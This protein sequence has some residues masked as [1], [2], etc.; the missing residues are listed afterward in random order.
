MLAV[1]ATVLGVLMFTRGAAA[2]VR[3]VRRGGPAPDRTRAPGRRT[4]RAVSEILGHERFAQR[5]GVR[6]AHW[7]VMLGFP[8]LFL[9][10]V[11]G[12]GQ[13]VDPRYV[14][15]VVGTWM[16]Y[17]WLVD[18]FA[19]GGLVGIVTLIVQR[20]RH[21][22]RRGAAAVADESAARRGADG[23]LLGPEGARASRFFGSNAGQA[24]L[25]EYV[26][27]AV[28]VAIIGL[29]ALE[30]A[31][32]AGR[33]LWWVAT[34]SV[35]PLSDLPPA[36]LLDGWWWHA[37]TGPQPVF[38]AHYPLTSWLGSLL[39]RFSIGALATAVVVLATVKIVVS[40]AWMVA[41]GRRPAMGVAWHRFV[42]V[43]NV[44]ARRRP[45]GGPALGAAAPLRAKDGTALDL[46][47]LDDLPEDLALGVGAVE[48]FSWKGLLDLAS[49]TE[50][51]R[52]TEQ[53]P[54]WNTGKPLS[55]K[56]VVTALRDH[57]YAT[58]PWL[59]RAANQ[60]TAPTGGTS[61]TG[62]V[63]L[64]PGGAGSHADVD[65][66]SLVGD[67]VTPEALWDCTMCGACVQQCPVDIEHVDHLLDLRRNQV[68]LAGA[69]PTE[70][71]Q[72]FT[73]LE[74]RGN[75]WGMPGRQ[76]MAWAA[77]LDFPVPVIGED[78]EDASGLDVLFWVGCAGAY[79]ERG[80]QVARAVAELLH[81]AGVSFAVLGNAEGCSGDPARRAGNEALF[82]AL[83][84]QT[85]ETFDAAKVTT[86]VTTCAHCFNT[87]A[88]EYPELGGTYTVLH[89]TELL[90]TLVA[91]GRLTPVNPSD[92]RVTYHDP[93]YL[94]RH[95]QV[96][97]PPRALLGVTGATLTEM[98]RSAERSFCCGGGGARVWMEETSGRRIAGDRVD[99][100]AGTGA[101]VVATAC[102]FCT[103]ML[104]DAA[105][106]AGS[107]PAVRDVA[108]VLL[109]AVRP[110]GA[111]AAGGGLTAGP[112]A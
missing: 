84:H 24:Y 85:I 89:H 91:E 22:P 39:G 35:A 4:W 48:D 83:A 90:E 70:L 18:L 55:P 108:E 111:G 11:T 56:L 34:S 58:T 74:R 20:Q 49:C 72:M 81:T 28:V 19:W 33:G 9:T 77:P 47:A 66:L 95:N 63:P 101:D 112:S 8:L 31:L 16:P 37:T 51:G 46:T 53:C 43:V 100:A 42:A 104:T 25:V 3:M 21:H 98:P 23:A 38:D 87:I 1:G 5:P 30:Y 79:D 65:V 7:V 109:D 105:R 6:A 60:P 15:P 61:G 10:L 71:G 69:F 45:E 67:V 27:L 50:C 14:L 32:G 96:Y 26:I 80:Q 73:K 103:V 59:T 40:M 2:I 86:V 88:H 110:G 68:L 57:A 12:Y 54:A 78:V 102:P 107:A 52:C 75:P 99:E 93:C 36:N 13:I 94:G 62:V 17:G 106:S 44:W 64:V 97:S 76:R 92:Q 82:Q 29:R 41:V